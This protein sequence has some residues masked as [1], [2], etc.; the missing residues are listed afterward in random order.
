MLKKSVLLLVFVLMLGMFPFANVQAS[1]TDNIKYTFSNGILTISGSGEIADYTAETS[2]PEWNKYA[3]KTEKIIIKEGITKIGE[4]AFMLFQFAQSVE[5]PETV[6][7]IGM[8]A[9]TECGFTEVYIPEGVK[10]LENSAFA[11]CNFLT[12][13]Y[14]PKSVEVMDSGV[15][16]ECRMLEEIAVN[17]DNPYFS[18]NDGILFN[19]NKTELICYPANKKGGEYTVP[20][21]VKTIAEYAFMSCGNLEKIN[22]HD[23]I[24]KIGHMAFIFSAYYNNPE[25]WQ[26]G[27]LYIDK[28][29]L[30][31][32]SDIAEFTVRKGT[33]LI[34][35]SAFSTKL[36][37]E[38]VTLPEGLLYIGEHAFIGSTIKYVNIPKS[39]IDIGEYAFYMCDKLNNIS[40]LNSEA[41]IGRYAFS[42]CNSFTDIKV[43]AKRIDE[44]AFF[45]CANLEKIRIG[46]GIEYLGKD[47]FGYCN[48]LDFIVFFGMK[49]KWTSIVHQNGNDWME[50]VNSTNHCFPETVKLSFENCTYNGKIRTP[51][52]TVKN[53][54]GTLLT[55]GKHYTV[56]YPEGRINAGTYKIKVT[57]KGNYSG[58]K[59]ATYKINP[60][61]ATK[62]KASLS[63]TVYTYNGKQKTPEVTVKSPK[64]TVLKEGKHYTLTYPKN[65]TNVGSY[66]VKVTMKGNYSGTKYVTFKINP[67]ATEILRLLREEKSYRLMF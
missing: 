18:S 8:G 57:F 4:R 25:N 64:G 12:K 56:A 5:I 34:A 46:G 1:S 21:S 6:I 10:E 29:L 16:Y 22:L 52:V 44:S 50:Y 9:F 49:S 45:N 23:N 14:I 37:L 20:E 41:N 38:K 39:V 32:Q 30:A 40:V 31:S 58:V 53:S 67:R 55:E 13:A 66:K 3:S 2:Q 42:C 60:I 26:D 63:Q 24:T 19:K 54:R 65:R 35:D 7:H 61:S 51:V 17:P 36:S 62:V 11:V 43:Y 15:F 59:Y 27:I 47:A 33:E 48:N 28:Y